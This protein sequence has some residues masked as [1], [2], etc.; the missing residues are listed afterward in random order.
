MGRSQ[1]SGDRSQNEEAR[2]KLFSGL[3]ADPL[4]FLLTT[5][6][7]LLY[8]SPMGEKEHTMKRKQSAFTLIEMVVVLAIFVLLTG[9]AIPVVGASLRVAENDSTTERMKGLSEGI[10]N[11]YDDTGRFPVTLQELVSATKKV[12]GWAGPYVNQGP[13][14]K[15]ENIFYDAWQNAFQYIKVDAETTRLRSLG[16]NGIDEKGKGDDVDLDVNVDSLL[17]KKNIKL[18]DEMNGAINEYNGFYRITKLPPMDPTGK[19]I[20][21]DPNG[22]WHTHSYIFLGAWHSTTHRHD[23]A[24][25]HSVKD[26]HPGQEDQV[27]NGD[28]VLDVPLKNPWTYALGLL[29]TRA[30]LDNSDGHCSNDAWGHSFIPS[31]DPVTYVTSGGSN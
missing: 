23:L 26:L 4:L 29:L 3:E 21:D 6:F 15:K 13:A 28:T 11:F 10:M 1:K 8:F 25:V 30:L 22:T 5:D 9:I 17:R 12:P 16:S 14:D 20:K 19:K 18:L 24:L 31:P 7:C 2:T 27:G